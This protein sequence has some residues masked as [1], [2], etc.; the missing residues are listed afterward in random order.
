MLIVV[1]RLCRRSA[2]AGA[3]VARTH[4]RATPPPLR[5]LWKRGGDGEDND[6]APR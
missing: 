4:T 5:P 3:G 1:A 6:C 2:P